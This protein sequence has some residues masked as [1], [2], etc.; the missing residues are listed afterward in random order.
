MVGG[1][2][3]FHGPQQ[4]PAAQPRRD[5]HSRA[6]I[7]DKEGKTKFE[8]QMQVKPIINMK[9]LR[10]SVTNS[11]VVDAK[12][13]SRME[14]K[15]QST[16]FRKFLGKAILLDQLRDTLIWLWGSSGTFTTADMPNGYYLIQGQTP[17][18]V[19]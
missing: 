15:M 10:S 3:D 19:D 11:I 5:G 17:E 8:P 14:L 6:T 18:M 4:A 7:V 1:G 2:K 16:L 12:Y 13:C 9:K